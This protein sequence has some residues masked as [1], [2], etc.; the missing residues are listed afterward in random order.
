MENTH[1]SI[2]KYI[3]INLKFCASKIANTKIRNS[4]LNSTPLLSNHQR[5]ASFKT[6]ANTEVFEQQHVTNQPQKLITFF[7]LLINQLFK[8]LSKK[9]ILFYT[10]YTEQ[11]RLENLLSINLSKIN[12]I[13]ETLTEPQELKLTK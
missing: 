6:L 4:K 5:D 9:K 3:H 8:D 7:Y 1:F 13:M 12:Y 2:R 10:I 11:K